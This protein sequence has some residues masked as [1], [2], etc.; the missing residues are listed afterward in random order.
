M[1]LERRRAKVLSPIW[2]PLVPSFTERTGAVNISKR[3]PRCHNWCIYT[4]TLQLCAGE[5][6]MMR[7][8]GRTEIA[9]HTWIRFCSF[10]RIDWAPRFVPSDW[11]QRRG[12]KGGNNTR[13]VDYATCGTARSLMSL[14]TG[15]ISATQRAGLRSICVP[16][17]EFI[18]SKMPT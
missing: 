10:V 16:G 11:C 18:L 2:S 15:W 9:K 8:D 14:S 7:A 5:K 12:K 4:R 3:S 17:V 13:R 1:V 6:A